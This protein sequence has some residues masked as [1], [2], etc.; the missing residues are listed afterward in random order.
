M[1]LFTE[2]SVVF[3]SWIVFFLFGWS[4]A[5]HWHYFAKSKKKLEQR[6]E[7]SLWTGIRF[8]IHIPVGIYLIN[9]FGWFTILGIAGLVASSIFIHD[10]S[11]YYWRNKLDGSYPKGWK[12]YSTTST[13]RFTFD[14]SDRISLFFYGITMIGLMFLGK[15]DG[16]N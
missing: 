13:A 8:F 3:W 10:R 9:Q 7:H 12:S 11:Y 16:I 4:E 5:F 2:I 1:E 14:Y 6:Y 15:Y